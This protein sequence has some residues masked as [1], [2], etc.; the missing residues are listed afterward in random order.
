MPA[1]APVYSIFPAVNN[2]ESGV[3]RK[4][5]EKQGCH[6]TVVAATIAPNL[7]ARISWTDQRRDLRFAAYPCDTVYSNRVEL[8]KPASDSFRVMSY[9]EVPDFDRIL[10][11]NCQVSS[12]ISPSGTHTISVV[13]HDTGHVE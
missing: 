6:E 8:G 12:G 5:P 4:G 1:V 11:N 10:Y 13:H 9:D 3:G 7:N 2:T